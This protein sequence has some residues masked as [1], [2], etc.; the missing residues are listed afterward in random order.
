MKVILI[1]NYSMDGA[2]ELWK[3]KEFPAHHLWGATQLQEYGIDVDILPHEKFKF[4]KILSSKIKLLGDLDQQIRILFRRSDY[5]LVYSAHDLTTSLLAFLHSVGIFRKPMIAIMHRSFNDNLFS[6]L[7]VHFF[8]NKHDRLICLSSRIRDQLRDRFGV[9]EK[10]MCVIEWA[11]DLSFYKYDPSQET[12]LTQQ[13]T[14]KP[15]IFTSAGKTG[16]DYQTLIEA[17]D[18]INYP[19]KIYGIEK[20]ALPVSDLPSNVTV[21]A[22][23]GEPN[24]FLP[25]DKLLEEYK[26][27]YVIAIPL[28]IP[29]QRVDTV[30]L[31]GLTSLLEA[32][33]MGKAVI[34]TR[35]RQID[36]DVEKEG[37]G[38]FVESGDVEGW[39]QAISYLGTHP[40]IAAE[41]GYRAR[42]LCEKKY[43]LEN[44]TAQLADFLKETINTC[45]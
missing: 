29:Q 23:L 19:L 26:Q 14:A 10:K 34:M 13:E 12:L 3:K 22:S 44:F 28:D 37:I 16:R 40:E 20:N 31:I 39:K 27:A 2:W 7:F 5:D 4:L 30:T 17:F 24:G 43:S 25:F 35:N 38:I 41:M 8:V 1:N 32:M 9:S 21:P 11:I 6:S 33:A 45:K 15:R 18:G 36:I 42:Q